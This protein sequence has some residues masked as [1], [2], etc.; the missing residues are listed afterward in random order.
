MDATV[1]TTLSTLLLG[2]KE[3]FHVQPE[4]VVIH[5]FVLEDGNIFRYDETSNKS[6]VNVAL[7]SN[8][9]GQTIKGI[10][11]GAELKDGEVFVA[12]QIHIGVIKYVFSGNGDN[13]EKTDR[14]IE[15]GDAAYFAKGKVYQIYCS[16]HEVAMFT[17]KGTRTEHFKRNA[18]I[19]LPCEGLS[20]NEEG[21]SVF[22]EQDSQCK[23]AFLSSNLKQED[24]FDCSAQQIFKNPGSFI[25]NLYSLRYLVVNHESCFSD[26]DVLTEELLDNTHVQFRYAEPTTTT[27][28]SATEKT[29]SL[30]LLYGVIVGSSLVIFIGLVTACVIV[31]LFCGSRIRRKKGE[32]KSPVPKNAAVVE[33]PMPTPVLPGPKTAVVVEPSKPNQ[34][35][36][37][38]GKAKELP[39]GELKNADLILDLAPDLKPGREIAADEDGLAGTETFIAY[40]PGDPPGEGMDVSPEFV[41]TVNNTDLTLLK[42]EDKF[43]T[44]SGSIAPYAFVRT[45]KGGKEVFGIK[46]VGL[47]GLELLKVEVKIL[48]QLNKSFEEEERRHPTVFR[49]S[50][51]FFSKIREGG[52]LVSEFYAKNLQTEAV[53]LD[54]PRAFILGYR[55]LL[56]LRQL[57]SIGFAHLNVTPA[58]FVFNV[59]AGKVILT[60]FGIGRRFGRE[61][62]GNRG[63][64]M[65]ASIGSHD[66]SLVAELDDYQSW[67]LVVLSFMAELPYS[68]IA[69]SNENL[70]DKARL[71]SEVRAAKWKL[72]ANIKDDERF[73]GK[74]STKILVNLSKL[75]WSPTKEGTMDFNGVVSFLEKTVSDYKMNMAES[76][77]RSRT[78][79]DPLL[80]CPAS[81]SDLRLLTTP[82]AD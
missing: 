77:W 31:C 38:A 1:L 30:S 53:K 36:L 73:G 21:T 74:E 56:C 47:E 11:L 19:S 20:F 7:P 70:E 4:S 72:I 51:C 49:A 24:V 69:K 55:C 12:G 57:H 26:P 37:P 58:S 35:D 29:T 15:A 27:M 81:V 25:S 62:F 79:K 17:L 45:E 67:L 65:F 66:F 46:F 76:S 52:I 40:K 6:R 82:A 2:C 75:T 41:L 78:W 13:L 50:H 8:L 61:R 64:V 54:L 32:S 71:W 5:A 63:D 42:A 80:H 23:T 33:P 28:G 10:R 14:L 43:P 48:E 44:F 34:P 3:M 18:N 59:R 60:E 22:F 68:S 39:V 9:E 16:A